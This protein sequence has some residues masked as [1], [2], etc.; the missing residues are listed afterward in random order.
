LMR[1]PLVGS[2]QIS[3]SVSWQRGSNI[4]IQRAGPDEPGYRVELLPSADL[5]R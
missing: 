5:E 3:A 4:K 1:F 2:S